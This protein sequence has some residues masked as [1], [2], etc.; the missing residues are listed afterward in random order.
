VAVCA[1]CDAENPPGFRFCGS[2]GAALDAE[3]SEARETRKTVT[4]VFCDVTGST[5]LGERLDPESLRNV[6]ARY[7][8][9][10][11]GVIEHHGGTVEKFI[12][13]AVMAVFGVPVLHEDDALRAVRAAA[14]MCKALAEL[15]EDLKR[16]FGTTLLVRIGVNTGQVVAGTEERLAT[17]DAVNIAARLEQAAEPGEIL[18]GPE[19]YALVRDAVDVAA[20]EPL[21]AKGKTAH[22]TPHRLL[23]VRGGAPGHAR[24]FDVPLVGR[25]HERRLLSDAW[26]RVVTESSCSLFTLLGPAGVGKSRLVAEFLR[27]ADATILRGRCLSY[28]DGITYWPVVEVVL[29]LLDGRPADSEEL[30]VESDVAARITPLLGE[31]AAPS[32]PEEIAWAVRRLFEARAAQGPLVVV[33][34]DIHWGEPTFLDLVEH[35]AGLSRGAPILLLCVARP[36]LFDVRPAWGGGLLNA[37]T[38]LLEPLTPAEADEL[39]E[40]LLGADNID[41]ALRGRIRDTAGGNP[42][43]L[44]EMLAMVREDD[45]EDVIV[46][47]TIQALLAARLDQLDPAERGVLEHGSVEGEV[48]HRG[49][50]LALSPGE[51][52]IDARLSALVR[53]ELVRPD[54]ATLPDDEAYRFRHL[55]IRDA[56]YDALPKAVRATLHESFARWL[57][58]HA[59][60]LVELDEIVGYHF[61]QAYRYREEL[62]PLDETARTL[63]EEAA[64]RLGRGGRN[65]LDRGDVR[66]AARLLGRAVTLVSV[67]ESRRPALL[68][69]LAD[70]LYYSGRLDESVAALVE[71]GA[72]A[73][74]LG[75]ERLTAL[76]RLQE[77]AVIGQIDPSGSAAVSLAETEAIR[78]TLER[79]GDAAGLSRAWGLAGRLRFFLGRA[80]AAEE[81][82]AR[83]LEEARRAGNADLERQAYEWWAGAKRHGPSPVQEAL[84]F[85]DAVPESAWRNARLATFLAESRGSLKAMEGRFDEARKDIAYARSLADDFGL[86][87]RRGGISQHAGHVEL[88]A[89]DSAAAER[90]FRLGYEM[91]GALGE[92]GFRS[93][94]GC[95]LAQTLVEQ[96]RDE[97]AEQIVA[98]AERLT[99][100]D[101]V[102][103]QAGTKVVRALLLARQGR[104]DEAV[105]LGREAVALRAASDYLDAHAGALLNLAT[106][107]QEAGRSEEARASYKEAAALYERK[108]NLVMAGRVGGLLAELVGT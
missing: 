56:A 50:V 38:V 8:E 79:V 16:D 73:R 81:A 33:F 42:L 57:D 82:F 26:E 43:Y 71:A 99:Q 103:A 30:G 53:K 22:L 31:V 46:P 64:E 104:Y 48:F 6:M 51:T 89:G 35:V 28:G 85:L 88:L 97:E 90:E 4:V 67:D 80:A 106:A 100:S 15:N 27:E 84:S 76:A 17:G 10:M 20:L 107:Y 65:A 66:A 47:P 12:G 78:S 3:P 74:R 96:G 41:S 24:R 63:G 59:A 7:F 86:E 18:I 45:Q 2:C 37:T 77:L 69:E 62:G 32:T 61:E 9:A 92:T 91:L 95:L 105:E 19:T 98:E 55:L 23:A 1:S 60:T 102:D 44:E 34:D 40:R 14:D 70:A 94:M 29:Q 49:A 13:D 83:S 93:T 54:R 68:A 75:D 108:G 58:D 101:D 39:I 52:A 72:L 5:A 21:A 36:E 25:E 87:L 11:R